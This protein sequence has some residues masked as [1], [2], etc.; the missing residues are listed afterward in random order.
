MT[1]H[2]DGLDMWCRALRADACTDRRSID[3]AGR[4]P[5]ARAATAFLKCRLFSGQGKAFEP[6]GVVGT[7]VG[8][9]TEQEGGIVDDGGR[10]PDPGG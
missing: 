4:P 9:A 5:H 1:T 2:A 8:V 10:R 7:P 3:R 6:V